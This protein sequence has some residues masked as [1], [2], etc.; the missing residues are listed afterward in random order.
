LRVISTDLAIAIG[1]R[2]FGRGPEHRVG[3]PLEAGEVDLG[4]V[5]HRAPMPH[6]RRHGDRLPDLLIRRA[7][8]PGGGG[9]EVDAILARDL[10]RNR[11]PDQLLGLAVEL[12]LGVKLEALH[13]RPRAGDRGLRQLLEEAGHEAERLLDVA[14]D[15]LALC[16]LRRGWLGERCEHAKR[17][18]G[19]ESEELRG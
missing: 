17:G 18:R 2:L 8:R 5:E 13:F 1:R 6:D 11:K 9:M 10:G 12:R 19:R 16:F 7:V 4:A 15:G 3:I 14:I